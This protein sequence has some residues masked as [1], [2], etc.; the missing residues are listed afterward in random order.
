MALFILLREVAPPSTDLF[1]A[2]LT[3]LVL[4]HAI[5]LPYY[6]SHSLYHVGHFMNAWTVADSF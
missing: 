6:F 2:I 1:F 5:S 4:M 3:L